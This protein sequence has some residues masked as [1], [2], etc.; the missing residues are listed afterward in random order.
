MNNDLIL[1]IYIDTNAL[2]DLLAS[3]EGGFSVVEKITT[4]KANNQGI[5]RNVK[6]ETGTEFGIPNVLSLLKL[7][8]GYSADW[9][10]SEE[11]G[12]QHESERYHTYGSLLFRLVDYLNSN[13]LLKKFDG[14][15]GNWE[16]LRS[17]DF[18]EI[19]GVFRPNPF[20]NSLGVLDRIIK[21]TQLSASFPTEKR[22]DE[23]SKRQLTAEER[24]KVREEKRRTEEKQ[25]QQKTML[26][27]ME[28]FSRFLQGIQSDLQSEKIRIFVVDLLQSS[29]YRAVAL[30]YLDYLRDQTM[31][32]ISHKEYR[33]LGKVVRKV[34]KNKDEA[35]DLLL[36]TG[37][38]G[39]SRDM[40]GQ[41]VN[42][43]GSIPNVNLPTI[44]TEV[45]GPA[46]EVIPV[47]VYV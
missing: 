20:A 25:E 6:A 28:Q 41:L 16:T 13:S 39:I 37:L 47:A 45:T 15:Q 8:L 27:Q 33:L 26:R 23:V 9:K 10:K 30:L 4:Q 12:E 36:G 31:N 38:G 3:I 42:I 35:I 2:L 34:E 5:E 43:I 21:I 11:K 18:V 1:P 46:L 40:L 32:E 24:E 29:E 7:T 22:P 44:Q 14:S 19:R 17:S